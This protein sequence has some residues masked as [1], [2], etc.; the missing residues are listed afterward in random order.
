[1]I[2]SQRHK[3]FFASFFLKREDASFSEVKEAKRLLSLRRS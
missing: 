1:M 2:R 3:S